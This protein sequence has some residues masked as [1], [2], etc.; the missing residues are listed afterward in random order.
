[1]SCASAVGTHEITDC[2]SSDEDADD[3]YECVEN[4]S[5]NSLQHIKMDF[6]DTEDFVTAETQDKIDSTDVFRGFEKV[7]ILNE[8]EELEALEEETSQSRPSP[9]TSVIT[10]ERTKSDDEEDDDDVDDDDGDDDDG[11]ACLVAPEPHE[12][13]ALGDDV[14]ANLLL[15]EIQ[16]STALD[17]STFGDFDEFN[18]CL[19]N[20]LN[21]DD[22]HDLSPSAVI[23]DTI[24]TEVEQMFDTTVSKY[25][26]NKSD[27]NS[28]MAA[29][30][31]NNNYVNGQVVS[32]EL[33]LLNMVPLDDHTADY[34]FTNEF[35]DRKNTTTAGNSS[36]SNIIYTTHGKHEFVVDADLDLNIMET[37]NEES[38]TCNSSVSTVSASITTENSTALNVIKRNNKSIVNIFQ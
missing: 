16:P 14:T 33:D 9:T 2:I 3:D 34:N 36:T 24:S 15:P 13:L 18:M 22:V 37:I 21:D 29:E 28:S 11:M 5:Q 6:S 23:A 7:L 8:G 31:Q 1:M 38:S 19:N 4:R 30:K 32:A 20:M 25:D 17:C 26:E 35:I 12:L 10:L 27:A